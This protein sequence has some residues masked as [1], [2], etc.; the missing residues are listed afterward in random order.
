M[1]KGGGKAR[2]LGGGVWKGGSIPTAGMELTGKGAV[3]K[4]GKDTQG[5]A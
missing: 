2:H 4:C 5:D 3:D 1:R